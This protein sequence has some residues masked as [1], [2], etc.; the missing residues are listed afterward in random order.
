MWRTLLLLAVAAAVA[1][2]WFYREE[3]IT[4]VEKTS[5]IEKTL[6]VG[7]T[8][9]RRLS[10]FVDSHYREI[11]APLDQGDTVISDQELRQIEA[12]LRDLQ[13]GARFEKDR[14]IYATGLQVSALL[15]R[16]VTERQKHERR[17]AEMRSKGFDAPLAAPE[18]REEE[19]EKKRRFFEGGVE[20][21]WEN[22]SDKL[23][24]EV[25]RQYDYLR[26]L[27]R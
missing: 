15:Q 23:R 4:V 7:E 13:A 27:E 12:S 16:A 25:D 11:F 9:I 14:K 19:I 20:R 10:A 21:S 6:V 26:L 22:V 18:R 17:L 8:P 2:L 24:A 1:Y 3:N 5:V